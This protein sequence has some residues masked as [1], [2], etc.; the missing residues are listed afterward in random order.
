M[1]GFPVR[2]A[3]RQ[4]QEKSL[5]E[6]VLEVY[7]EEKPLMFL[8]RPQTVLLGVMLLKGFLWV[9]ERG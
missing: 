5:G 1:S 6:E 2:V 3:D 7:R 9:P 8:S 4:Q